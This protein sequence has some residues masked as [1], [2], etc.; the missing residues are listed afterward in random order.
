MVR[1]HPSVCFMFF[2][3]HNKDIWTVFK[4][5]LKHLLQLTLNKTIRQVL[6]P[7]YSE[8]NRNNPLLKWIHQSATTASPRIQIQVR[9]L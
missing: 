2:F 8:A 9:S 7:Q 4:R 6:I 3:S 1:L 5:R